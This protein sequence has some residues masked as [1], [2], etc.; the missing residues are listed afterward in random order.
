MWLEA[1]T[2]HARDV[3]SYFGFKVAEEVVIGEGSIDDNGNLVSGGK[4]LLIYGMIVEP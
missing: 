2:P 4:G 1:T 3:Y